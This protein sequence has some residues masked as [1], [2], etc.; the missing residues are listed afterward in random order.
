MLAA[1]EGG[2]VVVGG[3]V[4]KFLLMK[5]HVSQQRVVSAAWDLCQ[6]ALPAEVALRAPCISFVPL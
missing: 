1:V 5:S 3:V 4:F 2:V 6:A